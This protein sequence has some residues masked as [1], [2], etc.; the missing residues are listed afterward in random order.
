[1]EAASQMNLAVV[2][3]PPDLFGWPE[4]LFVPNLMF[5]LTQNWPKG[6]KRKS[7]KQ[8]FARFAPL[9]SVF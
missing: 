9:L 1:M 3:R 4:I 5:F 8:G 7:A 6:Y 2:L